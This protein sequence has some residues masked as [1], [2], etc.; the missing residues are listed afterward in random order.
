MPTPPPQRPSFLLLLADDMGYGDWPGLDGVATP[1]LDALAAS[2]ARLTHFYAASHICSPAR[3][4]MLTGRLPVR[5]GGAGLN[6]KGTAFGPAAVGGLPLAETTLA[7]ALREGAGY[8]TCLVGK[9]HLGQRSHFLPLRHGFDAFFGLPFSADLGSTAWEYEQKAAALPLLDGDAIVAQP[10]K[11]DELTDQ[12]V[13]YA[14]RFLRREGHRPWLL[15]AA[16][17]QPHVPQ[18]PAPRWCNTSRR[19]RYG[20]ALQEMDG[21]I[22]E[23]LA[24][25]RKSGAAERT[26]TLFHSDNG[27]WREMALAGGSS[28]VL[29]GGKFTTWE[30]GL[31]VPAAVHHPGLVAAGTVIDVPLSAL[32]IF[33]TLLAFA[34]VSRPAGVAL[35]GRDVS[36][37]LFPG[38]TSSKAPAPALVLRGNVSQRCLFFYGGTPGAMCPRARV[39]KWLRDHPRLR[40]AS[41]A[42]DHAMVRACPG[43]W[44]VRCG[45]LK[46]HFVTRE[47]QRVEP[48]VLGND[49]RR[50]YNVVDD[51]GERRPLSGPATRSAW[52]A[53]D[54]AIAA[55]RAALRRGRNNE[56]P[57]VVNQV[58]LGQNHSLRIC[59]E[60]RL[61]PAWGRGYPPCTCNASHFHTAH[62]CKPVVPPCPPGSA[63][64]AACNN[65]AKRVVPPKLG[66]AWR[67]GQHF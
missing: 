52:A 59:C 21:A 61:P 67:M 51:P 12:M 20:D 1:H 16:F 39:E 57:A 40:N 25:V 38:R 58:G 6:W 24:A 13:G 19:G 31:R 27:P 30:G 65:R 35:D 60:S 41:R 54:G 47:G 49:R 18:A 64:G 8:A 34:G 56:A 4:S 45:A 2:G 17:H 14:A 3:G 62:V 10:P 23:L 36:A 50:L 28:G 7:E 66:R 44:A 55:H 63:R 33:P 43:L 29:R 22:G 53:I 42:W 26:L 11:L 37:L 48:R 46:G 32:D 15:V 5:W 9:W